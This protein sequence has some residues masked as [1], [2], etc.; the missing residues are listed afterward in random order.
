MENVVTNI[1]DT[2][3]TRVQSARKLHLEAHTFM[4]ADLKIRVERAG[5]DKPRK[6]SVEEREAR[7]TRVTP[8]LDDGLDTDDTHDPS[9]GLTDFAY[10]MY[11]NSRLLY[12]PWLLCTSLAEVSKGV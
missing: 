3:A 11:E 10:A 8:S 12:V 5:D 9:H 4:T 7:R 2:D 1:V 6:M